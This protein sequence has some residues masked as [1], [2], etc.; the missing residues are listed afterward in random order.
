MGPT[1]FY[2]NIGVTCCLQPT[3]TKTDMRWKEAPGG[4]GR[5]S[6]FPPQ[7]WSTC[8]PYCCYC[9]PT[10]CVSAFQKTTSHPVAADLEFRGLTHL[11]RCEDFRDS[12]LLEVDPSDPWHLA[13]A[14][15]ERDVK[16][17]L[18]TNGVIP[19]QCSD[20]S[21]FCIHLKM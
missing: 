6:Q 19:H 17:K 18:S 10:L 21:D 11:N 14:S 13:L 5:M 16:V 8:C 4:K 3:T 15:F 9:S 12:H 20:Q 7:Q 2:E 1:F